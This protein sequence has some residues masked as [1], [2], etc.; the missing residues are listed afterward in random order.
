MLPHWFLIILAFAV[1][2]LA[3]FQLAN[4]LKKIKL[5]LITG[6]IL[7]GMILGGSVLNF[8]P[9]TSIKELQYLS[10]I[11][12]AM[13]AFTAGSELFLKDLVSRKKSIQWMT[14]GQLLIT[15]VFSALSIY[16]IAAH[17]PFMAELSSSHKWAV[18]ILFASIFVARSP[19]SA[20]AIVKEMRAKGPFT[21]TA[22]GVTVI[23]DVVV[24]ILFAICFAVAKTIITGD[25]I[26]FIFLGKL[27]LEIALSVGIG[28]ILGWLLIL[29]FKINAHV[30][31]KGFL[32]LALGYGAYA[33]TQFLVMYSEHNWPFE[34]RLEPLLMCITG[35]YV[36]TNYSENRQEFAHILE[37]ISPIV[38]VVFF[39]YTGASLSLEVVSK[40]FF[41]ALLFFGLR[42]FTLFLGGVASVFLAKDNPKFALVSWMPYV[43]QAG[44]ALGLTTLVA[45][46]FPEW[47][48]AF[49]SIII[50]IVVLNQVAGP[51]LFKWALGFVKE[52]HTKH[53]TP[54]FDGIKDVYIFG[55]ENQSLI[56]AAE[57]AKK[58]WEPK[59]FTL[60]KELD[61]T[62]QTDVYIKQ[63]PDISLE[64]LKSIDIQKADRVLCLL[65]DDNNYLL[66]ERIFEK[67]G[68]DKVIVRL[69]DDKRAQSFIDLGAMVLQPSLAMINLMDH[70]LRAPNTTSF[71]LGVDN[72]QDT[73]DIPI[74]NKDL[75][76]IHLRD[77]QVS[78]NVV[79]LSIYRDGGSLVP[80]GYTT[81]KYGD[82]MA[83]AGP[84]IEIAKLFEDYSGNVPFVVSSQDY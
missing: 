25:E 44:V 21:K 42:I 82:I 5:P 14:G 13:I 18:S 57:L 15:F 17:V 75:V 23:I 49:E 77:L 2:S 32:I 16:F 58:G 3:A 60:K 47:G 61:K 8:I 11:A 10:D 69:Q 7:T 51:P 62:L 1:S 41:V 19:S 76:G 64:T 46:T 54:G 33:L 12:L 63:I 43:T 55:L 52:T 27:L 4:Y 81:L 72:D 74:N 22:I 35:A 20:I 30:I 73:L 37:Y 31:I 38:Y 28:I 48:V 70:M 79:I 78:Q 66:T 83:V 56:L 29:P 24:I 65:D 6:L 26:N 53:Q 68:I 71:L 84:T 80:H 9:T 39:T 50:A 45:K 34:I 67:V 36:L 59:I 40:V